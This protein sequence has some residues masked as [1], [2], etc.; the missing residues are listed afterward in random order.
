MA[1]HFNLHR[2]IIVG[3]AV[4][5]TVVVEGFFVRAGLDAA[6]LADR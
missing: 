6:F 4:A 1:T 2:R 5:N 3:I